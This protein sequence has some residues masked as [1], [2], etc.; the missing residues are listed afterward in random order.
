[1]EDVLKTLIVDD[2]ALAR[3]GL[4]HRLGGIEDL[5]IVAEARN[6][7]EALDLIRDRQPDLVFL[8]I[9]MPGMDGF[10][11]LRALPDDAMPAIV[12][13]TAFDDYAIK[14]FEANALDY[15][16]KPI[17]DERLA[18]A[19]DRVRRNRDEKRAMKHKRSLLRLVSQI[20]GEPVRSM[21]ELSARGVDK[22]KK[23][24][25]PKLAIRDAGRT[26]WVPQE[27]IEWI[28]AAGDYM[29]VHA[30]GETHIMRMTMKKLEQELDPEI[31]Q[32]IHRSTIVNIHKVRQM[33]AHINGEYFLTLEGGHRIKLS[34]SYK[35]KLKFFH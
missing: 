9:Q 32:R 3:R 18:E 4:K 10:D 25:K 19:L 33:Q 11:V 2:E 1:M 29:C 30:G 31:L 6:G 26:T 21:K 28:D 16:L 8:D 23:K 22:L 17:E 15:L 20:T 14:A 24:E 13:V 12:F 5:E 35:D 27:E 7:R 34:R